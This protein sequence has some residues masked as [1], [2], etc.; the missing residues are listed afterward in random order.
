MWSESAGFEET[1]GDVVREIPEPQRD[2]AQVFQ[3]AVDRFTGPVTGVGMI[4]EGQD[5]IGAAFQGG[6]E[7]DQLG[8]RGRHPA[9][10]GVDDLLNQP[11][12]ELFVGLA[13]GDHETLVDA[14][15][16]VNLNMG[17]V[18]EQRFQSGG[19]IVLE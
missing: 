15:G 18:S 5:V 9:G 8:Q 17:V 13:V 1:P 10:E 19:L 16:R 11:A 14:P 2:P 12:P 3:S 6:A 4:E 7:G